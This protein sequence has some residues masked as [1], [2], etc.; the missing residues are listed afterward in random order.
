[1]SSWPNDDIDTSALDEATDNP[2]IARSALYTLALRVKDILGARGQPSGVADLDSGGKLPSAR[3]PVV[4]VP[5]GGTG[6]ASLTD[7]GVLYGRGTS[8]VESTAVGAAGQALVSQGPGS[9]PTWGSAGLIGEVVAW[10]GSS[11]PSGWLE[12]NG[13]NVSR[14][15]YAALYT[16]LGGASS[17]WGQGDGTTTFGVPDLRRRTVVGA[18]GTGTAT[19]GAT[20]GSAGGEEE[21]ALTGAEG[22]VHNHTGST[23]TTGAHRHQVA[24]DGG[25]GSQGTLVSGATNPLRV[26]D[27]ATGQSPRT[28]NVGN[29]SHGLTISNAGGGDPHNNVQP[30]V[31]MRYIIR[32]AA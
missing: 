5:K 18:G 31:V 17:P 29:H 24:Y 11:V 1:M 9:P 32:A 21:H 20:V 23:T 4:S 12:C 3:L 19:L 14:T 27:F 2:Q 25:A 10:P 15:T 8:A 30:S 6:A 26:E 22:P 7:Y 13:Q 28:D 16:A